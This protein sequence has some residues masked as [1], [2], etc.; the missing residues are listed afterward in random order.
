MVSKVLSTL[1][2]ISQDIEY[3]IWNIT[4]QA[5]QDIGETALGVL[6]SVLATLLQ[7]RCH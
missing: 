2:F 3:R 1:A 4:L 7:E 5:V 6:G